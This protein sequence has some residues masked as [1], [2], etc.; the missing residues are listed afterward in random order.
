MRPS[1]LAGLLGNAATA[2]ILDPTGTQPTDR[3]VRADSASTLGTN[4]TGQAW[5]AHTGTWGISSNRAYLV[6]L[7]G[8]SVA[9]FDAGIGD[10]D[11]SCDF[12]FGVDGGLILRATDAN[13]FWLVLFP[14]AANQ[15]GLWKRVA[16]TY[17][18]RGNFATTL[19]VGRSYNIRCTVVANAW[20]V[21]LDGVA[22]LGTASGGAAISDAA[23]SSSTR[24]GLRQNIAGT[25]N[26][27]MNILAKAAGA[28]TER[29]VMTWA[30]DIHTPGIL[31]ADTSSGKTF[32]GWANPSKEV[33]TLAT[34]DQW[35]R[36]KNNGTV[37]PVNILLDTDADSDVDDIMDVKSSIVY[38]AEGMANLI[39]VA[40]TT[41][42]S[43][44]PGAVSAI[45]NHY[46]FGSIPV[47][48]YAPLGTFAPGG[49]GALVYDDIYDNASYPHPGVGLAA[50]V[51]DTTTAIGAWLTASSGNVV[52]VMT[53]FAKAL[54]HFLE[55]SAGNV[56][57]FTSKVSKVV[58]VA[59]KYPNDG[60]TPEFN[61]VNNA[62]DWNWLATNCPVPIVWVGIEIGDAVGAIGGT[63]LDARQSASDIMRYSMNRWT[64]Q[65]AGQTTRTPW[66]VVGVHYA[67]EGFGRYFTTQVAGT[68]AI[69][70]STGSNTFTAGAGTHS[71][72]TT[73]MAAALKRHHESLVAAD[74]AQGIKTWSSSSAWA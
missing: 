29:R 36:V 35:A 19:T 66:G 63:Y 56:T 22:V 65:F 17:T 24:V 3:F 4:S 14:T 60:G 13:N 47:S 37:T 6:T 73:S 49:G 18:Q 11:V 55:A 71:Y 15:I 1:I 10:S 23:L 9:T 59:G 52:Y 31:R 30:G 67:V 34:G 25:N 64:A 2:Q 69:N 58:A 38:N 16:G 61:L 28:A 43:K 20:N 68:N 53:G 39:G 46:G 72:L 5:T 54:R 48:S 42:R 26:R 74:V 7:A 32:V 57:L 70:S 12:V 51:T 44:A 21:Y 27:W 41:S 45:L 40:V 50:T 8:D 33:A 62:A